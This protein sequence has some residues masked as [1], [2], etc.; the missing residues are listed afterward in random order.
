MVDVFRHYLS[1]IVSSNIVRFCKGRWV[2]VHVEEK[3]S[4]GYQI[5]IRYLRGKPLK[6]DGVND[7]LSILK[8]L[9]KLKPRTIYATI[10]LYSRIEVFE[11]VTDLSNI[12][13]CMPTWDVDNTLE[14]WKTTLAIV[15]EI[16]RFLDRE[17]LKRSIIVKWSGRGCHVHIHPLAFS[18]DIYRRI[19]PLDL[20]YAIVE[21]VIL[22]LHSRIVDVALSYNAG[23]LKVENKIDVQ[24]LF[25]APLSLHRSLDMVCVCIDPYRILD[26]TL[27][28]ARPHDFKHFN[29]WDRYIEGE[30]DELA[31]K[32]FNTVGSYIKPMKNR[33]RK[34]PPLDRQILNILS[35]FKNENI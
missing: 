1:N 17:G 24:R 2:G 19:H 15:D 12:N 33:R 22:G 18:K 23:S 32:S 34:H 30:G 3:N 9:E 10:S 29:D 13:A 35:R 27:E 21:Y 14:N 25:T 26:F 6:I 31:L 5:L 4:S 7:I 20:A 28:M 8:V 11:D 16:S